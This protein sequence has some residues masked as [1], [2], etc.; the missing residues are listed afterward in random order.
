MPHSFGCVNVNIVQ[1]RK[2]LWIV[3]CYLAALCHLELGI[4]VCG[5]RGKTMTHRH[6]VE[7]I[8]EVQRRFL[9]LQG[10]T[11]PVITL[12]E[13]YPVR[14]TKAIVDSTNGGVSLVTAMHGK[15]IESNCSHHHR[16]WI[17]HQ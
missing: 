8:Q 17:H 2:S 3:N 1:K 16:A 9:I 4:C 7:A 11:V 13:C 15:K 6:L 12:G 10:V 5:H 14:M